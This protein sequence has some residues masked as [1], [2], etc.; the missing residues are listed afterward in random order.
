MRAGATPCSSRSR[1]GTSD[2]CIANGSAARRSLGWGDITIVDPTTPT[3]RVLDGDTRALVD[4]LVDRLDHQ[5]ENWTGHLAQHGV[6]PDDAHVYFALGKNGARIMGMPQA[7]VKPLG[8]QAKYRE[9]GTLM[10]CMRAR[11]QRRRLR[12]SE[13]HQLIPELAKS[14]LDAAHYYIDYDGQLRRLGY[15]WV[16]AGGPVDHIVRSV[17]K[18]IIEPRAQIPQLQG[19][20]SLGKF[21]VAIVTMHENKCAEITASL[22]KLR[23]PVL[24][25][26]EAVPELAHLLPTLK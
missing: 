9:F 12:V 17:M 21:I 15:I 16:E 6:E 4:S 18:D 5:L 26:V 2:T 7:R 25:R 8:Q 19:Q 10:F 1:Q 22:A 11:E 24:F 3:P 13:L 14:R 20:M 23:T